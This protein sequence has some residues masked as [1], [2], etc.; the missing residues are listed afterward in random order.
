V[1][2]RLVPHPYAKSS[3]PAGFNANLQTTQINREREI[4]IADAEIHDV[5]DPCQQRIF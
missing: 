5:H 3:V 2:W 4:L 1:P